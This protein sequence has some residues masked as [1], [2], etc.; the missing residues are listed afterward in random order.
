MTIDEKKLQ[1]V[2]NN[3]NHQIFL[4]SER[5][6][7]FDSY[8]DLKEKGEQINKKIISIFT[9]EPQPKKPLRLEVG[10]HYLTR[11]GE[12]VYLYEDHIK[13]KFLGRRFYYDDDV[14]K[15]DINIWY[16]GGTFVPEKNCECEFDLIE[17]VE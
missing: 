6:R 5:D 7:Y 17:E 14:L 15:T 10:K 8:P 13:I 12:I 3:L 11:N 2:L 4:K 16:E 1:E 9:E